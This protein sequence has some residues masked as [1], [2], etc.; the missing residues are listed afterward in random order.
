VAGRYNMLDVPYKV[1]GNSL[2]LDET[3][4]VTHDEEHC[5]QISQ[6]VGI[7]SD[8]SLVEQKASIAMINK[9]VMVERYFER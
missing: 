1:C 3:L 6:V 7:S 5:S 9:M 4:E 2:V 8:G